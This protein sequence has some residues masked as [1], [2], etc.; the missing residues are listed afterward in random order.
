MTLD[1]ILAV[2]HHLLVFGKFGILCSELITVRQ[3]IDAAS[4]ARVALID[5]GYGA[6]A[7]AIVA[8]GFRGAV[9]AAKGWAYYSHNAFFA[10]RSASSWSSTFCPFRRPSP[11]SAGGAPAWRR[12]TPSWPPSAA[13]YWPSSR[14][15][16][17]FRPSPRP[18]RAAAANSDGAG[19]SV[20]NRASAAASA[21]FPASG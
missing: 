19:Q 20:A 18:W 14:C 17:S 6:S 7:T 5:L 4:V 15:S 21:A 12:A 16:P 8:V 10:R 2:L 11:S 3:G 9:F 13:S 1:L